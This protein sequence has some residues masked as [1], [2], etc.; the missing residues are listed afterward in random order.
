[1]WLHLVQIKDLQIYT[2][3][4][5][6][7][8]KVTQQAALLH[9]CSPMLWHP[10]QHTYKPTSYRPLQIN[11]LTVFSPERCLHLEVQ[12]FIEPQAPGLCAPL[13]ENLSAC[14]SQT[15]PLMAGRV[16]GIS[17]SRSQLTGGCGFRIFQGL[18]KQGWHGD[19]SLTQGRPH[20]TGD[21]ELPQAGLCPH[22]K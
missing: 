3:D 16:G 18:L 8:L 5:Y 13:I 10:Q 4:L 19:T 17:T 1:M 21:T 14:H 12:C 2:G 7:W 22:E 15:S 20:V 6:L 11:P 9:K